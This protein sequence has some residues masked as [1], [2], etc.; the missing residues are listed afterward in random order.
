MEELLAK[1][2]QAILEAQLLR[3]EGSS[4]R[5]EAAVLA[6]KLGETLMR[7]HKTVEKTPPPLPRN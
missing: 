4:L 6:G 1:A 2:N 3:Q 7:A 5:V